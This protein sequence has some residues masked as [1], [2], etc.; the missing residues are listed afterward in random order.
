MRGPA[1]VQTPSDGAKPPISDTLVKCDDLFRK[2]EALENLRKAVLLA[3]QLRDPDGR[4]YEVEWK[5]AKYSFFLGR[6]ATDEAE[7]QKAF[8]SGKNAASIAI[9]LHPEKPDGHFWFAA[10][11]GELAKMSPISVGIRSVDDIR[12]AANAVIAIDPGYQAGSAYDILAQI[13]LGTRLTG[14]KP[15][16]AIGFLEKAVAIEASNSNNRIDLARA[17]L[18]VDRY[19]EARQQLEYV[20]KMEPDPEYLPEHADAVEQAKTMLATKF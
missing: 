16:K 17:Y 18:A 20:I 10:N 11:L 7:R 3:G 1:A 2:R 13:E 5:F 8:E 15:E 6:H 4:N 14:G 12:E 19:A 9:R